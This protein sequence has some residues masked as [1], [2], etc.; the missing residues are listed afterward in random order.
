MWPSPRKTIRQGIDYGY[1]SSVYDMDLLRDGIAGATGARKEKL[2][3]VL[4]ALTVETFRDPK[5]LDVKA[6]RFNTVTCAQ[7]H[8]MSGRDGVHMAINDG[9]NSKIASP[10]IVSEYFFRQAE[11]QLRGDME[12]WL[13]GK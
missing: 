4:D 10:T 11:A 9:I 13:A 12:K 2:R 3:F 6:L 1:Y 7:C 5:R 8:Q